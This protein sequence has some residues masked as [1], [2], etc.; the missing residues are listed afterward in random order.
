MEYADIGATFLLRKQRV[1]GITVTGLQADRPIPMRRFLGYIAGTL[2][3][4]WVQS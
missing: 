2:W 3:V 4:I 1:Y